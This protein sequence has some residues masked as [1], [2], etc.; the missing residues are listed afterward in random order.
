MKGLN[1]SSREGVPIRHI[2]VSCPMLG[3]DEIAY[4]PRVQG[5]R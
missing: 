2:V 3:Y 4:R 1:L 5:D